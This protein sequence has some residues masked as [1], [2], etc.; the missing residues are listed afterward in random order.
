MASN[1]YRSGD[2]PRFRLGHALEIGFI[3][4]GIFAAFILV[5]TYAR[6]NK[7]R[8]RAIANGAQNEYT[9]EELSAQG[10]KAVTFRYMF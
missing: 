3:V 9:A 2:G 7:N 5:F 1:F 10:D 4:V 8:D 6:I